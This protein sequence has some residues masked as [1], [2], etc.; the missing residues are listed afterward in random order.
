MY[1]PSTNEKTYSDADCERIETI[2][3]DSADDGSGYY[4]KT[5]LNASSAFADA[6]EDIEDDELEGAMITLSKVWAKAGKA[7]TAIGAARSLGRASKKYG[8]ALEVYTTA[9]VTCS[10]QDRSSSDD[11][12]TTSTTSEDD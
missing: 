11:D 10:T 3:V 12:D 8:K 1:W 7:R 6:A 5:A 2:E 4:G 9:L